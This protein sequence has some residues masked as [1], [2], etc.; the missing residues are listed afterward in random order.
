MKTV[1]LL[2]GPRSSGSRC[3]ECNCN[4][5]AVCWKHSGL[6]NSLAA[7]RW[8]VLQAM[9]FGAMLPDVKAS[10]PVSGQHVSAD[11]HAVERACV[12]GIEA[13]CAHIPFT[14]IM[15]RPSCA[16]S[17]LL[18]WQI[19]PASKKVRFHV[20]HGLAHHCQTQP[21]RGCRADKGSSSPSNHSKA[22]LMTSQLVASLCGTCTAVHSQ[23]RA[24]EVSAS[25]GLQAGSTS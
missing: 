1:V 14:S 18:P 7:C 21:L 22:L 23:M 8:D 5:F 4:E 25:L 13:D 17:A 9:N 2:H 12:P 19:L 6:I 16:V 20:E 10:L 3:R 24:V 11:L 15:V